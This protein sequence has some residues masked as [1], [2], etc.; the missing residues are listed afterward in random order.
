MHESLKKFEPYVKNGYIREVT[1]PCGR[2][3]LFNYTDKTTYENRWDEVTL[4]ARGTVY[5]IS[6]GKVVARA[7]NKFF[8][9]SQLSTDK[10][11]EVLASTSFETCE[12]MDGSLGS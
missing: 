1:S 8:N 9:F 7:F 3:V 11:K 10:Q 2:L 6:T 12:K 5:E 4:K